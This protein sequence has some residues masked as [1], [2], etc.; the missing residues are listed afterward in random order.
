MN[1]GQKH[2][3]AKLTDEDVLIIRRLYKAGFSISR[4]TKAYPAV[5]STIQKAYHAE[6]SFP[7]AS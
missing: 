7:C 1:S 2:H 6:V 5:F 3:K 4:I